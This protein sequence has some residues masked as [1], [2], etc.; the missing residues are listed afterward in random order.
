[1]SGPIHINK[2]ARAFSLSELEEWLLAIRDAQYDSDW[3]EA[4]DHFMTDPDMVLML[5]GAPLERAIARAATSASGNERR[6]AARAVTLYLK[7]LA[8]LTK[9]KAPRIQ[10]ELHGDTLWV[11]HRPNQLPD[12]MRQAV[13]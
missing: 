3:L 9:I 11:W 2:S 10:T 7:Q 1:M 12:S 13:R 5:T 8:S 4:L 6:M